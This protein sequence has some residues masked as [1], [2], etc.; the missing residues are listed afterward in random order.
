MSAPS[1]DLRVFAIVR[2]WI[3]VSDLLLPPFTF[4]S[5]TSAESLRQIC[6]GEQSNEIFER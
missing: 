3:R 2:V 6:R 5:F 1:S 4:V